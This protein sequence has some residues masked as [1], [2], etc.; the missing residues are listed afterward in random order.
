MQPPRMPGMGGEVRSYHFIKSAARCGDVTLIFLGLP[1]AGGVVQQEIA[2]LCEQVIQPEADSLSAKAPRSQ[3]R[4]VSWLRLLIT[5][6]FPW[7]ERWSAFLSMC[8]QHCL[9]Q[10]HGVN[11]PRR[12]S[13]RILS[14]LLRTELNLCSKLYSVPPLCVFMFDDSFHALLPMLS[15]RIQN[16]EFDLVWVEN[17][18]SYPYTIEVL[19]LLGLSGVPMICNAH[20]VETLVLQRIADR[21]TSPAARRHWQLQARLMAKVE[22]AAYADSQL[23]F[24]CSQQDVESARTLRGTVRYEVV[25]NGVDLQYFKPQLPQSTVETPT[26][27][28]TAGFGYPPNQ[29]G[30]LYFVREVLPTIRRV[31]PNCRFLFA[32]SQASDMLNR[33]GN[34]AATVECVCSPTDIRPC[35][36][37]AWVFVVPLLTGGG[38]RLKIVEAMA[39]QRPVVSTSLG[40]EGLDCLHEEHL[41]L[42][43]TAQDFAEQVIRLLQDAEL[44]DR[45]RRQALQWVRTNYDWNMLC[46]QIEGIVRGFMDEC[47]TTNQPN[48]T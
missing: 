38:T 18:L 37:Q 8:V 9:P 16:K 14:W 24:Q 23:V 7:R 41:L 40:A 12:L 46:H 3:S 34:D 21:A 32:G 44:R 6:L 31:I 22:K 36:E 13:K 25:G 47:S 45:L 35:F 5:V 39:M 15:Q 28:F 11:R 19:R 26:I 1:G 42:A 4:F 2:E 27:V 17:T 10:E 48:T 20:N 30:L 43:D 33:L 29:E